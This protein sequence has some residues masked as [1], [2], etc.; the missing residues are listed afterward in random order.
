[1]ERRGIF[2]EPKIVS[3]SSLSG[4]SGPREWNWLPLVVAAALVAGVV[5]AG[6]TMSGRSK[7]IQDTA[8][9]SNESDPYAL[10]LPITHLTMSESANLAGGKVTYLDGHI[11][12]MGDRTVT[13]VTVQ[14]VFKD[15]ANKVAQSERMALMLIRMREPYIDT[16][17]VSAAPLQPGAQ[18]DFRLN[19]DTLTPNWAGAVP[20]V[21]ILHIDMK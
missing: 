9:L 4:S 21:R 8:S 19:F 18:Q 6:L 11:A 3:G 16:E 13:G 20:E 2:M 15:Y 7:R 1:M 17:M 5:V 12:N 10:S 14:V